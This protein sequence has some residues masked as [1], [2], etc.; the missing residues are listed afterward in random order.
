MEKILKGDELNFYVKENEI[1][2]FLSTDQNV[3]KHELSHLFADMSYVLE[4]HGEE[5][6]KSATAI[7]L[8]GDKASND[9]HGLFQLNL[10]GVAYDTGG[11]AALA[12]SVNPFTAK[13]AIQLASNAPFIDE[14]TE[15]SEADIAIYERNQSPYLSVCK[16]GLTSFYYS[17]NLPISFLND[18]MELFELN[19]G[20]VSLEHFYNAKRFAEA[21]N[22]AAEFISKQLKSL[23]PQHKQSRTSNIHHIN[24][25]LRKGNQYV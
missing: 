2:R 24:Y 19:G 21:S 4:Q 12:P 22:E 3:T 15:C 25:I 16:H 10:D 17:R 9:G 14:V 1:E 8:V 7:M 5:V 13:A 20:E 11:A 6:L 18:T 23:T